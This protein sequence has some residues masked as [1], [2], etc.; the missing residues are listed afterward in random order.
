MSNLPPTVFCD[1]DGTIFPFEEYIPSLISKGSKFQYVDDNP[2]VK[3]SRD[4]ILRE[5]AE[6]LAEWHSKGVRIILVTGRPES[7]RS[8]TESALQFHGMIYDQLVMGCG[9]GRRFLINDSKDKSTTA[10]G[11]CLDRSI[12]IGG[13]DLD[14]YSS[15]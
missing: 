4:K 5:C 2:Y 12:G 14:V 13:I 3:V 7:L 10:I 11:I 9:S 6:K 15:S 1:I 8:V